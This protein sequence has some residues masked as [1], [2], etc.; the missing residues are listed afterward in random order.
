MISK[1]KTEI[2][3]Q[4][5]AALAEV[6]NQVTTLSLEIAEKVLRKQLE[7]KSKQESLVNDLLK[8]VKIN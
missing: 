1:A 8:E 4:K 2:D 5:N 3:N 6:K 7:D